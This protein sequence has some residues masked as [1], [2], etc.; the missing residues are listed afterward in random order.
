N[1]AF[2]DEIGVSLTHLS[3]VRVAAIAA[4]PQF[5]DDQGIPRRA[6]ALVDLTADETPGMPVRA[7]VPVPGDA[8]MDTISGYVI[9]GTGSWTT[10]ISPDVVS[11]G[12]AEFVL[13]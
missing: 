8:T 2:A 6:V 3:R 10:P 7:R 13:T 11:G 9:D 4:T 12:F 1:G 5:I